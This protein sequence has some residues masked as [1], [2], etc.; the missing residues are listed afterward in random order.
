MALVLLP[1]CAYAADQPVYAPPGNWVK[2]RE[3]P[4]A[5]APDT[6]TPT[7]MILEDMQ[8]NFA[9]GA[10]E[11]YAESVSK[12]QTPQGLAGIGNL[13][14][15]W[16]P[17]TDTLTIHKLH[18]IRGDQVIDLLA[19]GHAFTVLRRENNLEMA[20]LDGALTAAIQPEGLQVG[21]LVDFSFTLKRVDPVLQGRAEWLSGN[22]VAAPVDHLTLREVWPKSK[23]LRFRQ[24][25][26]LTEAKVTTTADGSELTIAMDNTQ[27]PKGPKGAPTRYFELGQIEGTEFRS[28][29]EVSAL[30][31]PLFE[32]ASTLGPQSPL[33]A[34]AAKI[35][36]A[37]A[38]PKVQA[39]AALKL[40]EDQVRYLFLGMNNGGYIPADADQTWSR[41][42]GDCKGK[43]AAL[44]A[45][46]HELG[47]E[48]EPAL[49]NIMFGDGLDE[50][51]PMLEVFDHV[52]V[53]AVI[54]GKVY[55]LDGT[56]SGDRNLDDLQVPA[57]HWVL[58]VQKSGGTLVRLTVPQPEKPLTTIDFQMDAS[59]GMD[60]PASVHAVAIFR[61]DSAIALNLRAK[62]APPT[63]LDK[64]M[65]D[66]WKKSLDWVEIA[67]V[68]AVYDEATGEERVTMD[69]SGEMEWKR[70]LGGGD[71]Q[72]QIDE[73][74]LGWKA[75]Y[76]REPASKQDAPFAVAF[77]F[78]VEA[79]ETIR[80]P[81]GGAG[82]TIDATDVDKTTAGMEFKRVAKI[83]N[84]VFTM[85]AT[86]EALAPEFPAAGA[87]EAKKELRALWDAAVY[88]HAPK[89]NAPSVQ[90]M[91]GTPTTADEFVSR[92]NQLHTKGQYDAAIADFTH[93]IELKPD[94]SYA[95]ADRGLAYLAKRAD[96]DA[97][98]DFTRALEL[99]PNCE[100]ALRGDAILH[101]HHSEYS[102]AIN[103][104]SSAISLKPDDEYAYIWRG[105]S[106]FRTSETNKAFE[107]FAQALKLN[108]NFTYG[109]KFRSEVFILQYKGE[110]AL[111]DI[112]K[113]LAI[114]SNDIDAHAL[115]ARALA[116]LNRHAEAEKELA[117]MM[118]SPP[119][120]EGYLR[121]AAIRDP[122]EVD[123]KLADIDQALELRPASVDAAMFKINLDIEKGE[124]K[125]A[126]DVL[127]RSIALNPD[128]AALLHR[129]AAMRAENRQ[130]DLAVED[131]GR[132]MA[133][134]PANIEDLRDSCRYKAL[135][136]KN[137]DGA[138][139]DCQAALKLDP[140][141]DEAKEARGFVYLRFGHFDAAIADYGDV[142]QRRPNSPTALFGRGF[143]EFKSGVTGNGQADL[144]TARAKNPNIDK[145]FAVVSDGPLSAMIH[146]VED[147]WANTPSMTVDSFIRRGDQRSTERNYDFA[148]ADFSLA[149]KLDPGSAPA[150]AKRGRAYLGKGSLNQASADFEKSLQ[151]NAT[152]IT[153][154]KGQGYVAARKGDNAAAIATFTHILD[155]KPDDIQARVSR[156]SVLAE[157][158]QYDY[159]LK[160]MDAV[161]GKA[162]DNPI[163]LNN[164]CFY[165]AMSGKDLNDA[166]TD[167][168]ASLKIKDAVATRDSRGL[169]NLRLGKFDDAVADYDLA[170]S[171]QP[172]M[173]PSLFGR[174]IAKLRK[175]AAGD[176]QA[177][178]SA[179]LAID[180]KVEKEFAGYGVTP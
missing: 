43:T 168:N 10:R 63:D 165:R 106:Y 161:V 67:K 15:N 85:A 157:D 154:L 65:R 26:G 174:G 86:T 90:D 5:P 111:A 140:T 38:D 87:A 62:S 139:A 8:V 71:R 78:F 141:S 108:P 42:F 48:A 50:R 159:A 130:F 98:A 36:A 103:E 80:L 146:A 16:K 116:L 96:T 77:P 105:F 175:G 82:F 134:N 32:K 121:R 179:A 76:D 7:R 114:N 21:D 92:G 64:N 68:D 13:A 88:L 137:F 46:L 41:R 20:M 104:L 171:Q 22:L 145:D 155:I 150:Y 47:V 66:Y 33:K 28:W 138:L 27:P 136:G 4:E 109:Y 124:L 81:G 30:M 2:Q 149:I 144:A 23:T 61:G 69:G 115:R 156:A 180:P 45:L 52:L 169:V 123:Q 170:L 19:G 167:C 35:K 164:R 102:K 31:A 122:S 101:T 163:W 18:I 75:D 93:A 99:D 57:F 119:T 1:V 56:R 152:E 127:D 132:I 84:G 6:G 97:Q 120:A 74:R 117:L 162:P 172:K 128:N 89:G 9:D 37:S 129:R 24:T 94:A 29:A 178:I 153:A 147:A 125:D 83:E 166:L 158:H 53:R 60:A 95:Y 177:D 72:Y 3:L 113:V 142:L 70:Y 107:D 176:G 73:S 44:I 55:W 79:K 91:L 49:A 39:M 112:D 17:D 126:S 160:E 51:L 133:K 173:A 148:I 58:P 151:L 14:L 34:E 100:Y 118:P 143:A 110:E 54:G 25:D 40:I 131:L 59:A 135:S 12:I 11:T